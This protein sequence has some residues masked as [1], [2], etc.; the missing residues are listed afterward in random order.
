MNLD[1]FTARFTRN[2]ESIRSMIEGI[3]DEQAHW[4]P[5]PDSWSILEVINHLYDEEKEDFW[6]RLD[7][8]L[9]KPDQPWPPIDP[10]GWVVERQYN[11]RQLQESLDNFLRERQ[12]SIRWLSGLTSPD[13]EATYA[14]PF[15]K[16]KA[17]D[18]FS[19]WVAHDL[20]HMRQLVELH[21][22][23]TMN[24]SKPYRLDYAGSW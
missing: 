12:A 13:W 16:I 17:G 11:Q 3:S 2:A 18:M 24:L 9:H 5:D 1:R 14:A 7:I 19:S 20:L 22:A 6:V 21:W 10:A 4:K 23:Y 15:G 8:I